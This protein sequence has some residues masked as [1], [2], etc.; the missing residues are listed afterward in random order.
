MPVHI[1][2][3]EKPTTTTSPATP[4]PVKHTTSSAD[5]PLSTVDGKQLSVSVILEAFIIPLSLLIF[6]VM[7]AMFI[8][9]MF[10]KHRQTKDESPATIISNAEV[11]YS[12][13]KKKRKTGQLGLAEEEVTYSDVKHMRRASEKW[14]EANGDVDVMY[15]SVVAVERQTKQRSNAEVT[16][17]TVKKKRKTGQLGLAEEEVTYSDVKHMRRASEK[18]SEANRDVDVMYSSVVAVERQT[19]Q[20]IQAEEDDVTYSRL[21]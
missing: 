1:T 16:Y 2:V 10:K 17:S 11:T 5:Q 9:F 18:W 6:I 4:E 7:V 8:W 20:M 14:S 19:K 3:T 15:S 21:A 13:V 12:T